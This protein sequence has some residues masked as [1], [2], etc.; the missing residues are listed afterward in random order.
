MMSRQQPTQSAIFSKTVSLAERIPEQHLL[1]RLNKAIDF[2]FVYQEVESLYGA[3]GNPSVPPTIILKLMVLLTIY[4]VRSE[5]ELMTTLPLRIDWLWFLGYDLE[6]STPHH[7]VLS[8]ARARWGT[9]LFE[10]FFA[11]VVNQCIEA[12][13]IDGRQVFVDS[14]LI[15]A[16][17]SIDSLFDK[18][19]ATA[20][21]HRRLDEKLPVAEKP[22]EVFSA[23]EPTT[24]QQS[25]E[26]A[27]TDPADQK[28]KNPARYRSSTDPDATGAKHR[29]DR[30]RPRYATHRMIDANSRIIT[31]TAIGPGHQNEAEMLV[32][33]IEQHERLTEAKIE[34]LTADGK[35]GVLQNLVDCDARGIKTFVTP[36]KDHHTTRGG[37]FAECDFRYDKDGDKYLCP[38]NQELRRGTYR[39][40]RDGYRYI[41]DKST[42]LACPFRVHCTTSK[43][44]PRTIL[45]PS[46]Q[47]LIERCRNQ[48]WS[49]EGRAARKQRMAQMEGSFARSTRFGYKR[50]RWRGINRMRIQDLLIAVTQNCMILLKKL[51]SLPEKAKDSISRALAAIK[52]F[53]AAAVF[54]IIFQ[55]EPSGTA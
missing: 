44:A 52:T 51:E 38:A 21:L 45:R 13:L 50:A 41:G 20:E 23:A 7:S 26:K 12:G 9:K 17:A 31:A 35:Y 46:K 34:T 2:D 40:E 49:E 19:K 36:F 54:L 30:M 27:P 37:L 47:E 53:F 6:T 16:N 42:C 14:S 43:T 8:K 18:D 5:R 15:D 24:E 4:N 11:R 55:S 33:L 25:C 39:P 3:V 32:P 29:G 1:R 10:T 48:A 22:V 28:Q